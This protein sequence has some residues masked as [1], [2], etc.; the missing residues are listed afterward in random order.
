MKPTAETAQTK[1]VGHD[2]NGF[3][4]DEMPLPT[5]KYLNGKKDVTKNVD[6]HKL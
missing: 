5:L 3:N 2:N 6:D 4:R 1:D